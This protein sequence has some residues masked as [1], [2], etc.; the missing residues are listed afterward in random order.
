MTND[1]K[2]IGSLFIQCKFKHKMTYQ[3]KIYSVIFEKRICTVDNIEDVLKIKRISIL[4]HLYALIKEKKVL[5]TTI[6]N[7]RYFFIKRK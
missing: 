4:R 2:L 6:E 5:S 3:Q 1:A 7:K